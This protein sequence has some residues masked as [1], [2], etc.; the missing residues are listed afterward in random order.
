MYCADENE[1][2]T[3]FIL[4]SLLGQ[5]TEVCFPVINGD[6]L[7]FCPYYENEIMEVAAFGI[8]QPPTKNK[9]FVDC[10]EIDVICV[11]LVAFDKQC[12]RLGR[13][14]GFYDRALAS[15]QSQSKSRP[16]LLG[17]AYELQCVE[18]IPAEPW[19]VPLDAVSTEKRLYYR[20]EIR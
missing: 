6:L 4:Q 19:D 1:V 8:M 7:F 15:I 17:L 5:G 10:S 20:R 12:F 3:S 11:P 18:S 9:E 2:E 16:L 14:G 13:G